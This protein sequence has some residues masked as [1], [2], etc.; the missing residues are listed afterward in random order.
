MSVLSD[1]ICRIRTTRD[2]LRPSYV[3]PSTANYVLDRRTRRRYRVLNEEELRTSRSSDTVFVIGAGRSLTDISA[4]EWHRVGEHDTLSLSEIYRQSWLAPRYHMVGELTDIVEFARGVSENPL[5]SET[6][7]LV[8]GGWRATVGNALL[9]RNL[10]APETRVFRYRRVSRG[11]Y[12]PP[13]TSF[14]D[15]VVH[16]WNSAT[17]A[18]NLALLIGW[19]RIVLTGIDLY[20]KEYFWL[21][22]GVALPEEHPGLTAADP[23]PR[24]DD[25]VTMLGRWQEIV[26]PQGVRIEVFNPRSLLA[27]ELDVFAWS[28]D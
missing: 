27:R 2:I 17:S 5:L 22:P 21:P 20:N 8:Q 15:G 4:E 7:F 10:L 19:Q 3:I 23:F 18:T 28:E 14:H 12:A 16:G 1:T 13:S 9:G 6:T 24:G 25:I 26:A 11:R